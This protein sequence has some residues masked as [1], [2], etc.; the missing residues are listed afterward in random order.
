M[1]QDQ[2]AKGRRDFFKLAGG[3]AGISALSYYLGLRNNVQPSSTEAL[4]EYVDGGIGFPIFRPPFLQKD[5]NFAAFSF[6]ADVSAL[7]ALC[8]RFLNNPGSFPYIYTPL[9][10]TVLLV[11]A[12]MQ[13]SSLDERDA[14]AGSIPE[15]DVSFWVLTVAFQNDM[16]HHLAWFVPSLFVNEGTSIATGREVYGFNKQAGV[17]NKSVDI[18]SPQFSVDVL[19]IRKFD[20]AAVAQNERLLEVEMLSTDPPVTRW[21]DLNAARAALSAQ[22]LN[23]VRPGWEDQVVKLV[24]AALTEDVP[25]V[26][27]KQFRHAGHGHRSSYRSIVEAPLQVREF[28][29]G[30]SLNGL[31]KLTLHT[32]DSHPLIGQLGLSNVQEA[33]FSAWMKLDCVLGAGEEY[34]LSNRGNES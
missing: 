16:P 23:D 20:P 2:P 34:L 4:H 29:E 6:P 30:G 25:L 13:V 10:R 8:D 1:P 32:L 27:N 15:T 17:I 24:T 33:S 3:V 5:V 12:D 22:L 28:R 9:T 11:Y 21:N 14:L 26:F 7:T 19:G 18:Q 31:V